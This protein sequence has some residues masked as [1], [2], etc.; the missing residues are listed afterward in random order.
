MM[1]LTSSYILATLIYTYA[2]WQTNTKI[3]KFLGIIVNGLMIIYDIY[4]NSILGT[5]LI[6]I[7]F[8]SSLVGYLKENR[9]LIKI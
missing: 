1:E 3:Y 8:V 9:M 2:L 5:I 7:S 4:I 6:S